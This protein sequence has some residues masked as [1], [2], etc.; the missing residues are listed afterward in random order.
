MYPAE[1]VRTR[2]AMDIGKEASDKEFKGIR[3]V[4]AKISKSD[5]IHGFY[6]GFFIAVW[7]VGIY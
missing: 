4:I 6:R 2:L 1:F 5:G 3:D 7:G